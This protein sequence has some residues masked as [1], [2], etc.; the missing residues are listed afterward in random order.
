MVV[1]TV[2]M[3]G[4]AFSTCNPRRFFVRLQLAQAIELREWSILWPLTSAQQC[5]PSR[6]KARLQ[7]NENWRRRQAAFS[8]E[9]DAP[10]RMLDFLGE[11]FQPARLA[12]EQT[13]CPVFWCRE[14]HAKTGIF[15]ILAHGYVRVFAWFAVTSLSGP[16][17]HIGFRNVAPADG[18]EVLTQMHR[19]CSV[20]VLAAEK[21]QPDD[22]CAQVRQGSDVLV[23]LRF[24]PAV[25]FVESACRGE[26]THDSAFS[27]PERRMPVL[28]IAVVA[29]RFEW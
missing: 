6:I 24:V 15:K 26:Q 14:N 23:H 12:F 5:L 4:P 21:R 28:E 29:P 22:G 20:G 16:S 2:H 13:D 10:N 11:Q 3:D 25:Q 7:G 9:P 19:Q 27:W 17:Q 18:V 1:P 8:P